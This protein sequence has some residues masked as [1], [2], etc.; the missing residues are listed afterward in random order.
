MFFVVG[1]IEIG[2][3]MPYDE[4]EG[5]RIDWSPRE[6]AWVKWN[7]DH[8]SWRAEVLVE[9]RKRR[10]GRDVFEVD[11][12]SEGGG[13]MFFPF[14]ERLKGQLSISSEC[15][16]CLRIRSSSQIVGYGKRAEAIW[17]WVVWTYL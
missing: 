12:R 6:Y 17:S 15:F 1:R 10:D 8:S 5:L 13:G 4:L 9:S 3:Y 11:G 7:V 2:R 14:C 16:L